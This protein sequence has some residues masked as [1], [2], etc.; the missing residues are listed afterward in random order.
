MCAYNQSLGS[1]P[2]SKDVWNKK[3]IVGVSSS[4]SS[5]KYLAYMLSGPVALWGVMF[6]SNLYTPFS[7]IVI[8][9]IA[10]YGDGPLCG[11]FA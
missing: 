9:C 3:V 5:F 8:F 4:A 10:E 1:L 11:M 6:L 2:C 7:V